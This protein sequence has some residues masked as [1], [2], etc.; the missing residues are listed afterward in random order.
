MNRTPQGGTYPKPLPTASSSCAAAR[1]RVTTRLSRTY[2][3][4]R[5]LE[6]HHLARFLLSRPEDKGGEKCCGA[7]TCNHVQTRIRAVRIRGTA[8]DLV[9]Q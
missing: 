7:Y 2:T 9:V 6:V 4:P 1:G 5:A 3:L 8:F